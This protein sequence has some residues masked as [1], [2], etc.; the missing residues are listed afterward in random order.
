MRA[1]GTSA[2]ASGPLPARDEGVLG[3]QAAVD[4]AG[5]LEQLVRALML[6][7][8]DATDRREQHLPAALADAVAPF[9]FLAVEEHRRIEAAGL[10]KDFAAH[11]HAGADH[12][13]CLALRAVV[14]VVAEQEVLG[15]GTGQDA[16][17]P[18]SGDAEAAQG[19]K[20]PRARL[21]LAVRPQDAQPGHADFGPCPHP[22]RA[23]VPRRRRAAPH[24]C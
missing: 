23:I 8:K 14:P 19:G 24:R 12:P 18:E 4:A 5:F 22:L 13:V 1:G 20:P 21:H 7:M 10:A 2:P 9:D 17:Q 15:D 16:V 3:G 11:E 6:E